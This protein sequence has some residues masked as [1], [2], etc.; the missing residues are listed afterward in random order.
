V[1]LTTP[2]T[3]SATTG[4]CPTIGAPHREQTRAAAATSAAHS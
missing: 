3:M 2:N 1:S 4:C